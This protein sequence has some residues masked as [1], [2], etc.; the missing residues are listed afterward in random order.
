MEKIQNVCVHPTATYRVANQSLV[1]QH[2]LSMC[3]GATGVEEPPLV[4]QSP[5]IFVGDLLG[6]AG[7]WS[8]TLRGGRARIS[9]LHDSAR[10]HRQTVLL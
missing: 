10:L 2:P 6:C 1:S 3:C 8:V 9:P 7:S 5:P 4:G